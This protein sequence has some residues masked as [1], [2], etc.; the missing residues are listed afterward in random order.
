MRKIMAANLPEAADPGL[1]NNMRAFACLLAFR[2]LGKV[3]VPDMPC[4]TISP[5]I[6]QSINL[7]AGSRNGSSG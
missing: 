6:K 4:W 1:F 5:S 3:I 7:V 2:N